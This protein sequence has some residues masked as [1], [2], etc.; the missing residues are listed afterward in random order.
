MYGSLGRALLGLPGHAG[1]DVYSADG[2]VFVK[3]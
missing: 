1:S 2:T 3:S